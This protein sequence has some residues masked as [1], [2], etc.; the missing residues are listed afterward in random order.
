[1]LG[2]IEENDKEEVAARLLAY[3]E[4]LT[5][6]IRKEDEVLYPWMDEKLSMSQVGQLFSRFA[7]TDMQFREVASHQEKFVK[8]MEEI[9]MYKEETTNV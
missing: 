1:M 2:A 9:I 5:A 3:R 4:L 6:H 7:A 8:G